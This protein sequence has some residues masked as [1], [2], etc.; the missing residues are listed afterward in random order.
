MSVGRENFG[1]VIRKAREA[2]EISLRD[3]AKR[4]EVSPTFLSKVE[5][6]GW[7][8]KEDK[9]RKIALILEIDGDE[10]VALAGR[11]PSDLTEIIKKHGAKTEL[12]SLL[13]IT[14]GYSAAE[15]SKL[16]QMAKK[17]GKAK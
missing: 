4:I 10:L 7:I 3:L 12:A 17:P 8:P 11:V 9:L 16:V 5:T 13:R 15:M 2:K 1:A 6:E 14:K